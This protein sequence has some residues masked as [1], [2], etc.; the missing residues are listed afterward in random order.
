MSILSR[1][2]QDALAA[3]TALGRWGT[4][5][6]VAGPALLLA[7]EAGRF[8]TGT[9]LVVDGGALARVF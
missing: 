4:P 2:Q 9:C 8:I 7:S 3:R 6:E 5:E 1:E